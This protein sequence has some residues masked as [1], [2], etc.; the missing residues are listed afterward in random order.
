MGETLWCHD[1]AHTHIYCDKALPQHHSEQSECTQAYLWRGKLKSLCSPLSH[2]WRKGAFHFV[3]REMQLINIWLRPPGM[4]AQISHGSVQLACMNDVKTNCC[5]QNENGKLTHTLV[6][7]AIIHYF[8]RR[9]T[10]EQPNKSQF[11]VLGCRPA[12]HWP[13]HCLRT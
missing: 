3:W 10:C 7:R 9:E 5:G 11:W 4:V 1:L 2:R 12:P 13:I 6:V 8:I